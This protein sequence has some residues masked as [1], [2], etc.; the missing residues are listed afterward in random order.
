[1]KKNVRKVVY[2]APF[3][4]LLIWI[5]ADFM[6]FPSIYGINVS[7]TKLL[8]TDP[9]KIIEILE[10]PDATLSKIDDSFIV[11]VRIFIV[12]WLGF[13]FLSLFFLGKQLNTNCKTHAKNAL[14][15]DKEP[16]LIIQEVVSELKQMTNYENNKK[17]NLLIFNLKCLEEK[18][19]IESEFGY[20]NN[21]VINCENIIF[22]HLHILSNTVQNIENG[23]FNENIKLLDNTVTKINSLLQKRS[24]L[25]RK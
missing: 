5:I 21:M 8:F 19:A 11:L 10:N 14:L 24:T 22:Q 1:M 23:D 12:T 2:I 7:F 25:K 13:I 20:G 17:M 16:Y 15:I 18:L 6:V 4:F 9:K 3:F